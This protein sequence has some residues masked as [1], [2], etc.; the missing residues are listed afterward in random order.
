[1]FRNLLGG[2]GFCEIDRIAVVTRGNEIEHL[3]QILQNQHY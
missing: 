3:Q 2:L 1:M